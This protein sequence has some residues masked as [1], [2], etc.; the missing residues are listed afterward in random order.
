M[1]I[2]FTRIRNA[3]QHRQT[4]TESERGNDVASIMKLLCRHRLLEEAGNK[5]SE[6]GG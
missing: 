4:P 6:N 2:I 5:A 3:L 1:Y